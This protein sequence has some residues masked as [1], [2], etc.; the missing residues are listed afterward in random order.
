[1]R[2]INDSEAL[3]EHLIVEAE[4]WYKSTCPQPPAKLIACVPKDHPWLIKAFDRNADFN[5]N[6]YT[7]EKIDKDIVLDVLFGI[8]LLMDIEM[9]DDYFSVALDVTTNSECIALKLKKNQDPIRV[10]ILSQLGIQH[11]LIVVVDYR[12][13]LDN[14]SILTKRHYI[15]MIYILAVS[16][17]QFFLLI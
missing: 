17:N 16:L 6:R 12:I 3:I 14:L 10:N 5:K 2:F 13:N 1:M 15:S 4:G 7:P 11:H 9:D 8:D